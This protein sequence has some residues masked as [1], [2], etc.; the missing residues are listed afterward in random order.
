VREIEIPVNPDFDGRNIADEGIGLSLV[1]LLDLVVT[2]ALQT[3]QG[4]SHERT[5]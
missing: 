5:G 3:G 4:R 1:A 2:T